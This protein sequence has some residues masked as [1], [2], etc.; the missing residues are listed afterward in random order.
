M[1]HE[2]TRYARIDYHDGGVTE[3]VGLQAISLIRRAALPW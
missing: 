3:W 2:A 1:Y